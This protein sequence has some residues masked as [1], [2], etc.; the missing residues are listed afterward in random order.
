MHKEYTNKNLDYMCHSCHFVYALLTNVKTTTNFNHIGTILEM[1]V[2]T[3]G[4]YKLNK[5]MLQTKY[6][7]FLIR[8]LHNSCKLHGGE[9]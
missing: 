8:I 5:Y 4:M 9:K 1:Y 7:F 6:S 3:L 2:S